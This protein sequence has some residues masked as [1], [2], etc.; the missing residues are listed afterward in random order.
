MNEDIVY[1]LGIINYLFL[2]VARGRK[3]AGYV[4]PL[5]FK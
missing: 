3:K 2:L 5:D 1:R 4:G